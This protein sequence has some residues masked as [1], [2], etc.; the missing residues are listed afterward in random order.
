MK[1]CKNDLV[2]E[3]DHNMSDHFTLYANKA[4]LFTHI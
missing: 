1:K 3:K 4:V 2:P